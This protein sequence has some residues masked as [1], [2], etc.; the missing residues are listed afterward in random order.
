MARNADKLG[1]IQSEE[2]AASSSIEAQADKTQAQA[3]ILN[4]LNRE[5]TVH[6]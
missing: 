6:N 4:V 3:S 5:W 2:A 1:I